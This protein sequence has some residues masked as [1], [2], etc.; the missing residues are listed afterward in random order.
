[1]LIFE[2]LNGIF[3][4]SNKSHTFW[5]YGHH[6]AL[7]RYNVTR[8]SS[9]LFASKRRNRAS[10]CV[11]PRTF[12]AQRLFVRKP[13]AVAVSLTFVLSASH[14]GAVSP[15]NLTVAVPKSIDGD[16]GVRVASASVP[17]VRVIADRI[18]MVT[19]TPDRGSR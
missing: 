2:T 9:S 19:T 16:M 1:M 5:Q 7:S 11:P 17:T 12:F 18:S 15:F 10:V 8:T 6:A 3:F 14:A 13:L 4:S